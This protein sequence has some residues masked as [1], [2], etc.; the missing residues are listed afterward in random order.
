MKNAY[1]VSR[2]VNVPAFLLLVRHAQIQQAVIQMAVRIEYFSCCFAMELS[3]HAAAVMRQ[4][5][6]A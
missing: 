2:T 5:T 1:A 6:L 3:S 4:F